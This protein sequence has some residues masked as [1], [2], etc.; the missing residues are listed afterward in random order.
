MRS[1][2][3]RAEATAEVVGS[4]WRWRRLGPA[5]GGLT[6]LLTVALRVAGLRGGGPVAND[7]GWAVS[8][9]RFLLTILTHPSRWSTLLGLFTPGLTQGQHHVY[10][11]GNDWKPGHDLP[12][13]VLSAMG[14]SPENLTWYSA[15][16]GAIMVVLLA[17]MAWRRGGASAGAV[18]GVFAGT[19]PLGTV[20]GHRLLGEADGM[21]AIAIM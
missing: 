17:A 6:L 1:H 16:A 13:G 18:A 15:A 4:R 7:E 10:P 8:N 11:L 19:L 9:G 21:A 20:Y 12:L 2:P 5:G 14:V 3:D